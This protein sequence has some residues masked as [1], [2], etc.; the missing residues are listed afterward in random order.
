[1]QIARCP[2]FIEEKILTCLLMLSYD[3]SCSREYGITLYQI[4]IS[5]FHNIHYIEQSHIPYNS[6]RTTCIQILS[7]IQ[8]LIKMLHAFFFC[9]AVKH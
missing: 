8:I 2:G 4:A 5:C 1:M 7:K 9:K 6:N 3:I